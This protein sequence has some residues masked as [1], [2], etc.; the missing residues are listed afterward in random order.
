MLGTGNTTTT[1]N[2]TTTSTSSSS[3][4][5]TICGAQQYLSRP[6]YFVRQLKHD[7]QRSQHLAARGLSHV[8][9]FHMMVDQQL[10][11][12]LQGL[13][14]TGQQLQR[15]AMVEVGHGGNVHQR[16]RQLHL[17][18]STRPSNACDLC[19]FQGGKRW[20]HAQWRSI[21]SL[22]YAGG[23]CLWS[24]RAWCYHQPSLSSH[25]ADRQTDRQT[26]RQSDRQAE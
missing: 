23:A 25:S 13:N 3:T 26:D 4:S 24:C 12:L 14:S 8:T 16:Q 6:L 18:H 15:A 1:N 9:Q 10:C 11:C 22:I 7:S 17:Q 19:C 20:C 2:T 21:V 5:S